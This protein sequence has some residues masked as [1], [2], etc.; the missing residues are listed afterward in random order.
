[1]PFFLVVNEEW[2]WYNQTDKS[3]FVRELQKAKDWKR[4]DYQLFAYIDNCQ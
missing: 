4:N 1:M 3:E 2:K